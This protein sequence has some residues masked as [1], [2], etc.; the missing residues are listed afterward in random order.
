MQ[1]NTNM[2]AQFIQRTLSG[3]QGRL[4]TAM[5][6]LSGGLRINSAADDPAGLAISGRM[7]SQARGLNQAM[8]NASDG[9]SLLQTA[10]SA[11]SN[12][13]DLLQRIREIGVQAANDSYNASDRTSMQREVNQMLQEINRIS[14][15]TAFN[16]KKLIDGTGGAAADPDQQA[17]IDGL[18]GAW[19]RESESLIETYYGL[20]G[21]GAPLEIVLNTTPQPYVAAIK[22]Q[23]LV[24]GDGKALDQE[25]HIDMTKNNFSPPNPPNGGSGPFYS[26]RIIAH[27]MVHAVMGRTM[28]FYSLPTWFQEGAAEFIHGADERLF[29]D[30][31]AAGNNAQTIVNE[32]GNGWSGSSADYSAGYAAVRYMHAELKANGSNGLRDIMSRLNAGDSLD[33]ALNTYGPWSDTNAFVTAF[34]TNGAAFINAMDL[35]NADTGAIGGFDADGGSIRTAESVIPDTGGYSLD[36]LAGFA[37]IWPG[38]FEQIATTQN[39]F[40]LQIGENAGDSLRIGIGAASVSAL[41]LSG[42]D[43][44]SNAGAVI[45]K[46]DQALTYLN[47]QRGS[48]GAAQNRLEHMISVS[49]ITQEN[50]LA[51][52]SRILDAD[53]AQETTV[54]ARQQILMQA[55]MALLAQANTGPRQ[56]LQALLGA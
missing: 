52:R 51:S 31:A 18:R 50:V 4:D 17:V 44:A 32:V 34:T 3:Q 56:V 19:L 14:G 42:I 10:D 53:Y 2:S 24:N 29:A 8:R 23:F 11:L 5:K 9:V 37:E 26:D 48:V 15:Q 54:L 20:K 25:L 1:I 55:S 33:V 22:A 40:N 28:D 7:T 27:E 41:G 49:A 21:D 12:I 47:E 36:P 35:T 38:G 6:R 30:L 45:G 43:V 16:G 13:G 39:F 46:V